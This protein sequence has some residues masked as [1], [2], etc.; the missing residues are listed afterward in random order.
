MVAEK[1]QICGIKITE[2]I[3]L[4]VKKLKIFIFTHAPSKTLPQVLKLPIP[5]TAFSDDLFFPAE[6]GGGILELKK[7]PAMVLLTG[8]DKFYHL[9]NLYIF[10]FCFVVPQF[11]FNH[12]EMWRFFN[13]INKIFT[14]TY[15][16]QE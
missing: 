10:G 5:Q 1:F 14:K 6:M 2:K 9:R 3:N 8:F 4:W 12:A 15:S 16:V 13:L 7:W 11:R